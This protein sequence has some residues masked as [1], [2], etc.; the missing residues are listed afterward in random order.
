MGVTQN[1]FAQGFFFNAA[2]ACA[3]S[4]LGRH[5]GGFEPV[6][7]QCNH[8]M[9]PQICHLADQ[10]LFVTAHISILGR[11][12]HLGRFFTNFF[13]ESVWPCLEQAGHIAS[14]GIAAIFR[15]AALDHFSQAGQHVL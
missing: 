8:A 5:V 1:G 14:I 6:V 13:Q 2:G 10:L 7:G 12:H 4:Q 11:H 3:A 15:Q 9:K